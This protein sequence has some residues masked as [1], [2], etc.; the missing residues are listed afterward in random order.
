[1]RPEAISQPETEPALP[2]EAVALLTRRGAERAAN[3][4]LVS[5]TAP[6]L[7]KRQDKP[8]GVG[9]VLSDRLHDGS[10]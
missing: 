2:T 8:E 5:G 6:C 1:M 3:I 7:M 10:S 4:T 9:A